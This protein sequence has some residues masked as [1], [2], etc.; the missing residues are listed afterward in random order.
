MANITRRD[1]SRESTGLST[2]DPFRMMRELMRG[3]PFSMLSSLGP[4]EQLFAPDIEIKETKN[5]Y[6]FKADLPGVKE[7]DLEISVTGNR[8]TIGGKREEEKKEE[9]ERYYSYERSFGSFSRSFTLPEGADLDNIKASLE[10]GVLSLTVPKK[11]AVQ[12]KRI[13]IGGGE[14]AQAAEQAKQ[15]KVQEEGKTESEQRPKGAA[16][17]A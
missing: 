8:L 10:S 15:V 1:E 4:G 3:D 5:A 9:G 14:K 13:Q 17:A 12:A 2:L 7:N 16:K 6:V 11:E